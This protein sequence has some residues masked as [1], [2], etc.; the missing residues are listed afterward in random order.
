MQAPR[1]AAHGA[2]LGWLAADAAAATDLEP[3]TE[4]E[5]ERHASFLEVFFDL[6]F[7]FAITQVTALILADT[8]AGGFA[9]GALVLGLVWWAWSGYAWATNA[10]D[11]APFRGRRSS[12]LRWARRS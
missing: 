10:V 7:I 8:S 4:A 12:S 2:R 5:E 11:R 3:P 9:R 1:C 6:V